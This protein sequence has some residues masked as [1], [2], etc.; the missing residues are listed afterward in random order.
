M[1]VSLEPIA[2][3]QATLVI[4]GQDSTEM[5]YSPAELETLPT[6]RVTTTTPWREQPADFDGVLLSDLLDAN[7]LGGAD[8]ILVTAENDY[9]TTLTRELID[10]VEILV[11][12]R[13]NGEPH[14]RRERGP[15]QFVIEKSQFE[16]SPLT[17]ESNFVWMAARIEAAD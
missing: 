4:V 9:T 15:I 11:A 3:D 12:T 2:H 1:Q 13:V 8:A 7:G 6:Y 5:S 14:S 16:G 10:S 17:S